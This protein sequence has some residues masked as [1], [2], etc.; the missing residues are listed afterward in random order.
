VT[1]GKAE[2]GSQIESSLKDLLRGARGLSLDE[3]DS[4]RLSDLA[5][6][7]A[8]GILEASQELESNED[9]E[10]RLM[11]SGLLEAPD[12]QLFS[13]ALTDRVH[14]SKAPQAAARVLTDLLKR[15]GGGKNFPAVDRLQMRA[16]R[17]F[18]S[19]VPKLTQRALIHR[20]RDEAGPYLW[21][22]EKLT[23]RLAQAHHEG[24]FV[25]LNF[26][27]EEVLGQQEAEARLDTYLELAKREDIDALSLKL[28]AIFPHLVLRS[29]DQTVAALMERVNLV[30]EAGIARRGG[31]PLLYFDMETYHDLPITIALVEQ[32]LRETPPRVRLGVAIQAYIP[33]ALSVVE[34]LSR[35]S[36]ERVKNGGVPLR[37]RLV[38]GAN[39]QMETVLASQ[40][41][42]SV[43]IFPDKGQVDAHFKRVLRK[44]A[45]LAKL[46]HI[47]LGV[48]SHNLFDVSYALLVRELLALDAR[49]DL[50]MLQG[51]AGAVGSVITRLTGGILIYAPAVSEDSFSSAVSYLVRR[52]DEN[53]APENFMRDAPRM[54]R[55][56]EAFE[57]QKDR[58]LRAVSD[59]YKD[60]PAT[61]RTQDRRAE[62]ETGVKTPPLT[63]PFLNAADTD[64]TREVNRDYFA[65]QLAA[66]KSD[67]HIL[68]EPLIFGAQNE[69]ERERTSG[70]DPSRPDWSYTLV[71]ASRS[72]IAQAIE[73][74]S[75][76]SPYWLAKSPKERAQLLLS[77]AD[78]LEKRRAVLVSAMVLDAGKRVEEADI[79]VSEAVDFARYYA[80]K[81]LELEDNLD[82]RGVSVVTPPWNFPLAIPLGGALAALAAGNTVILKPAPETPLVAFLATKICHEAGIPREALSF[83]PCRDE[84]AEPLIVDPRVRAVILTGATDTARLFRRMRPDL[85]LF[86]ETGGKNGAYIA[87]VSDRE[88]AIFECV[89]SAFGHA[90]QKCSALSFLVLH[91]EVYESEAFKKALVD[92]TKSLPVGSAWD[93]RSI[94]TPLINPPR[95]ALAQILK[96]GE[97]YGTWLLRP[98]VDPENPRLLSPGILWDVKP[99]SFPH[100][101]EFF[102]PI[103]AVMSAENIDEA[104]TLLNSTS[105]GLTAG[106]FSLEES[107][108]E[109]F[110]NGIE[111]GN[112]Y[113]N[114]GV[115][116]AVVGRQPFGGHKASSFGPGAK[117]GG[118]DYVRQL[119]VCRASSQQAR[120]LLEN[121]EED[122]E[123]A[124][125]AHF[126]GLIPGTAVVGEEN[127]LR[128]LPGK[129]AV[130]LGAGAEPLDIRFALKA[131]RLCRANFPLFILA[132][133]HAARIGHI[134]GAERSGS[135]TLEGDALVTRAQALGLERLRL[136]GASSSE[137]DKAACEANITVIRDP[138]S[139]VGRQELVL[140]LRSQSTSH[141]FHRH[142][143]T[144]IHALSRLK[145]ALERTW[146]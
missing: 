95:G 23:A 118:P 44:A 6:S 8:A 10:R 39:L 112:I 116:G 132:G 29:L 104:L 115:T 97:K 135:V 68:V 145:R 123:R 139:D 54:T 137:L 93:P 88:Q 45:T 56:D 92:A 70:F 33:E 3:S 64:F 1:D 141:A 34:H 85:D 72:D 82:P 91:R 98:E 7:L 58:F 35:E 47:T 27:G 94:V 31:P 24:I 57:R 73:T 127:Y 28:S 12:T 84:T 131:K 42:L 103:L 138:V 101:A 142:G 125:D 124:F 90:G 71:L 117:A 74:A 20:L 41:G 40:R 60:A 80:R 119:T 100:Q 53:T 107:D 144:S 13:T 69:T 75:E 50:E 62:S 2:A 30:V 89:K 99:G 21:D 55:D 109:R 63:E 36:A 52:L 105:Y 66:T 128:Y 25:N 48:G 9:R 110:V 61:F 5:A 136:V 51:M 121:R 16:A 87:P 18:G 4:K 67:E 79:E 81:T 59:S 43:P 146:D 143:N 37:I 106:L 140:Y 83:V 22:A 111:A 77:V 113:I 14:R 122:Y 96:V 15:T 49:L 130:V 120:K 86:A 17:M 133:D 134:L 102:G 114:R 78:L 129:T 19:V 38:K 32:L 108:H 11:L 76:H 26:L 126:R 65:R 46:G